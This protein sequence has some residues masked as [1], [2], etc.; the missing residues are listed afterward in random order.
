VVARLGETD[1]RTLKRLLRTLIEQHAGG[2][3]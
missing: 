3:P 1:A 2:S